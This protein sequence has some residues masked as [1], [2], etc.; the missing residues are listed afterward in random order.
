M[1]YPF[2]VLLARLLLGGVWVV[3]ALAKLTSKQSR[4]E[5]VAELGRIP[6]PLANIVGALL[7]WI[8]LALGVLLLVG[9]WTVSASA[10]SAALL[11]LFTVVIATHLV[12]G[13]RVAC[14]CFGQ[15]GRTTISWLSVAR[16]GALFAAAVVVARDPLPYLSLD[17]YQQHGSGLSAAPPPM[18]F[19][20]VLLIAVVCLFLWTL[21]VSVWETALAIAKAE[22]GPMAGQSLQLMLRRRLRWSE[23]GQAPVT[24]E[25]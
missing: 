1:A 24:K 16:N 9:K 6:R 8:E 20:P 25:E 22:G 23:S 3:A 13:Q 4:G 19:I 17:G 15:W 10:V 18:E 21:A 5:T 14:N 11:A 12:R 2:V 7:P